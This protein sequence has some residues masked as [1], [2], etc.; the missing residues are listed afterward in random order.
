VLAA[1]PKQYYAELTGGVEWDADFVDVT[2]Q[3]ELPSANEFPA[4]EAATE[5]PSSEVSAKDAKP[6]KT[7]QQKIVARI[8]A[9]AKDTG[10]TEAARDAMLAQG[11]YASKND[12]PDAELVVGW[13]THETA[14]EWNALH[15]S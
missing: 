7:G 8:C 11:G 14:A 12:V 15:P 2:P 4:L 13:F 6:A 9:V 5:K 3:A 1:Q 10:F